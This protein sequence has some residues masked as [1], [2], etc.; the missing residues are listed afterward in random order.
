MFARQ[1]IENE[2]SEFEFKQKML[3]KKIDEIKQENE[4]LINSL[5]QL[6]R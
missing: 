3:N 2:N 1:Y 4:M 5:D 6:Q